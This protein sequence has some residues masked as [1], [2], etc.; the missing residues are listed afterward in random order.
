M[1]S[2]LQSRR[3]RIFL[4]VL[5][6]A[7][8]LLCL[9]LPLTVSRYL[10]EDDTGDGAEVAQFDVSQS[11]TLTQ[12]VALEFGEVWT[13]ELDIVLKNQG[14]V[15]VIY[16]VTVTRGTE[17]LPLTFTWDGDV[18]DAELQVGETVTRR[19]TVAWTGPHDYIYSGEIDHVQVSVA[20]EQID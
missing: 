11:G 15:D 16:T 1:A 4:F 20:C 14:E 8:V 13:R 17:N 3:K 9:A 2:G 6:Y 12:T 5:V 10:S 18:D 19:L 7:L